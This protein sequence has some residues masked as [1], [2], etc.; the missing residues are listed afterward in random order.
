MLPDFRYE[1]GELDEIRRAAEALVGKR[2]LL[3][4]TARIGAA[5]SQAVRA[6]FFHPK[7]H[8]N[9]DGAP[10][11]KR[12]R[13]ENVLVTVNDGEA[14]TYAWPD[15][16]D[17]PLSPMSQHFADTAGP[18]SSSTVV[19]TPSVDTSTPAKISVE[20]AR[21]ANSTERAAVNP[22]VEEA[23]LPVAND[24]PSDVL[25]PDSPS[26]S[27]YGDFADEAPANVEADASTEYPSRSTTP[28]APLAAVHT[29]TALA[30]S[31]NTVQHSNQSALPLPSS[32]PTFMATNNTA[33]SAGSTDPLSSLVGW[34]RPQRRNRAGL[35]W[36]D[37]R[38]MPSQVAAAP[39]ALVSPDPSFIR[40]YS[41]N[42]RQNFYDL[43]A[44][45]RVQLIFEPDEINR[46]DKRATDEQ[47][48]EWIARWAPGKVQYRH[49]WPRLTDCKTLTGARACLLKIVKR[50]E[51]CNGC[52]PMPGQ[53]V[54][55]NLGAVEV[56]RPFPTYDKKTKTWSD[57]EPTQGSEGPVQGSSTGQK[58][59]RE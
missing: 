39:G 17:P 40:A 31:A 49:K 18:A 51:E 25:P 54:G 7:S 55:S 13:N 12:A 35:L 52:I 3:D 45:V 36:K 43:P 21:F 23:P 48:T 44:P 15:D 46:L 59:R 53:N 58:R 38:N 22:V 5:T 37:D 6:P 26:F 27:M 14:V 10:H 29:T 4:D 16:F 11:S 41:D 9:N 19:D 28:V 42:Q 50:F 1:S 33:S 47:R 2:F 57:E 30:S 56:H 34:V 20:H 32:G 24:T 8:W